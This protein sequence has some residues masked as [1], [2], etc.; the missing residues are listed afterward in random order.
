[1]GGGQFELQGSHAS[2]VG[3]VCVRRGQFRRAWH[4]AREEK[5]TKKRAREVVVV[6]DEE[7]EEDDEEDEKKSKIPTN[8]DLALVTVFTHI[9]ANPN[10]GALTSVT[11]SIG[12]G[13]WQ[14]APVGEGDT[15]RL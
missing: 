14:H 3:C 9:S 10:V 5:N 15:L 6:L 12:E 11:P 13:Q 7:D 4:G 2:A 8:L 1:M